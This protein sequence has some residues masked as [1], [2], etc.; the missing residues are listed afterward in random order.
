MR[1]SGAMHGARPIRRAAV[2]IAGEGRASCGASVME[3][4]PR[5]TNVMNQNK[6]RNEPLSDL[7]YD[8]VTIIQH[9]SEALRAYEKYMQD[10]QQANSP[11]CVELLRQIHQQDSEH[12]REATRHLIEVLRDG[13]MA[14]TQAGR[15]QTA[16]GEGGQAR[17]S[18]GS[19][20]GGMSSGG[21]SQGAQSQ[22]ASRGGQ[23]GGMSQG[24]SGQA[25]GRQGGAQQ[26]EMEEREAGQGGQQRRS[27]S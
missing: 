9:K 21:M 4:A 19:R 16:Q 17:M 24:E 23:G 12:V 20:E 3:R 1:A 27:R 11:E 5:G 2:D 22:A 10:A 8:W 18:Q 14:G 25:S 13:R 7:A 6:N 15:G 26:G